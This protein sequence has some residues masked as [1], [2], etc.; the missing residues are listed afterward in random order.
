MPKDWNLVFICHIQK[1][2]PNK[3]DKGIALVNVT[4][5]ILS[6]YVMYKT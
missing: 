6:H 3:E 5:K 1:K 2:D 4:Y